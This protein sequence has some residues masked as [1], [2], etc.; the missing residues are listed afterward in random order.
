MIMRRKHDP[1][2]RMTIGQTYN[3][4][5]KLSSPKRKSTFTGVY[6]KLDENAVVLTHSEKR[7]YIP[8]RRIITVYDS[9]G[10]CVWPT[11]EQD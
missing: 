3:I 9:E 6:S 4:A 5:W 11:L 10:R 1:I 2:E 8:I 7:E